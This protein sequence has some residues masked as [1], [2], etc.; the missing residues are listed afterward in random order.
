MITGT[1][2]EEF[3]D[4]SGGWHIERNAPVKYIGGRILTLTSHL[5]NN[6]YEVLVDSIKFPL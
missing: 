2:K 5:K 4:G 1:Y 3:G 6:E